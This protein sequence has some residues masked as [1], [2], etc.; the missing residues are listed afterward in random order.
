MT[1]KLGGVGSG[2]VRAAAGQYRIR[3]GQ[4]GTGK[5]RKQST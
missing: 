4:V 5:M 1:R 2:Q 3:L